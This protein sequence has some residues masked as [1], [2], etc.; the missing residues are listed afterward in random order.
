MSYDPCQ[1]SPNPLP[2]VCDGLH[3]ADAGY[4]SAAHIVAARE[5][6]RI[7]LVGPARPDQSWQKWEGAFRATYFA[8]DWKRRRVRCPEAR[9][10]TTWSEYTVKPSGRSCVQVGFNA[11][12]CRPCPS[13]PRCTRAASRQLRLH[14]R[15]EHEALAATRARL[16][17][18]AGRTL[19]AQRQGT[20]GMIS[21]GV[22][23]FGLRRTRYRGLAKTSLQHVATAAATINLD[24]L[25][26]WF[27]GRPLA[28]TRTSRS[29]ALAA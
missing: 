29:A 20:E 14:P 17:K 5:R 1:P 3:L 8:V 23:A 7:D 21:Q 25:A 13:R 11:A 27:N 18:E 10:S 12:D 9:E 4:V 19:Y 16:D 24:R 22:R 26:A 15:P 6:H 2:K 28:L